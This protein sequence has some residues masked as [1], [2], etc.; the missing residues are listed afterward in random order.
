MPCENNYTCISNF[1]CAPEPAVTNPLTYSIGESV[2]QLM[3]HGSS[4]AT[5]S[6][7]YSKNSQ[8]FLANYCANTWDG[9]CEIASTDQTVAYANNMN[10][11]MGP[12]CIG[13]TQGD[14]LI[15]NTAR[16]K[17]LVDP[18]NQVL[19]KEP[20]DP[21]VADSP[22]IYYWKQ[23]DCDAESARCGVSQ[24]TSCGPRYAVNPKTIDDDIVM[25]KIL[26]NPQLY[27]SL[28]YNIYC[29]MKSAGTLS[30]LQG[31]KLGAYFMSN[32]F[33]YSKK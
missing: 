26:C 25:N 14:M 15:L 33:M 4:T 7:Q 6:G 11:F 29:T 2:D 8:I 18:G 5:I 17:Y 23:Q 3:L 32:Q 13:L 16:V 19:V 31:T 12:S 21:N 10:S 30:Q 20:F 27:M 24:G 9:F 22:Y 1:G 28:L